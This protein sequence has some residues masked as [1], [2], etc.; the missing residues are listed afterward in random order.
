MSKILSNIKQNPSRKTFL[1]EEK[2]PYI[3]VIN[4]IIFVIR[5]FIENKTTTNNK[6][7][8]APLLVLN[9]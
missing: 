1:D 9:P 3:I 7:T 5:F 2:A 8:A 4:S 6:R